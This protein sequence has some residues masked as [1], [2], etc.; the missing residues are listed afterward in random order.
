MV[1]LVCLFPPLL[2]ANSVA[3]F[4]G[5]ELGFELPLVNGAFTMLG[6]WLVCLD[7][8]RAGSLDDSQDATSW[9]RHDMDSNYHKASYSRLCYHTAIRRES[10]WGH[11]ALPFG[12]V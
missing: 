1:P 2:K 12:T 10:A 11:V 5:Y 9:W 8:L 7:S 6:V 3:R 4:D